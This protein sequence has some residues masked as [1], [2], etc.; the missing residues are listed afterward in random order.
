MLCVNSCPVT[1]LTAHS[2]NMTVC[3]HAPSARPDRG[4]HRDCFSSTC[5]HGLFRA[6]RLPPLLLTVLCLCSNTHAWEGHKVKA[7]N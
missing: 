3:G 5:T 6:K 4:P 7:C 1:D 2:E